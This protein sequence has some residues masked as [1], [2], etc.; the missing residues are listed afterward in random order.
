MVTTEWFV[1]LSEA[2][3]SKWFVFYWKYGLGSGAYLWEEI[4]W[5]VFKE[6]TVQYGHVLWKGR[7]MQGHKQ[8]IIES[9][10]EE[11]SSSSQ[12]RLMSKRATTD[13]FSFS[14]L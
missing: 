3:N 10:L 11:K 7:N 4:N 12:H 8:I 14:C 2:L 13:Q 6:Q 1:T 5:K 9:K